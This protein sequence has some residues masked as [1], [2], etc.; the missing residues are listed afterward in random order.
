M[1]RNSREQS[2]RNYLPILTYHSLDD[3]GSVVSIS[4][5]VFRQ[6]M[7]MLRAQGVQALTLAA[8]IRHLH[9][10]G[11]FPERSVVI[12]FDD[13]YLNVFS[14]AYPV[15]QEYSFHA[16][17]F[18]ITGY[19]GAYNDWPGHQSPVGRLPLMDWS[20]VK[21]MSADGFEFG[22][23]TRSHP[24]LSGIPLERAEE[25]ILTSQ[26]QIEDKLGCEVNSFAYP[27][28]YLNSAVKKIVQKN[29]ACA[30]SVKLGQA[31]WPC[32]L[33]EL[34]RVDM[35]YVKSGILFQ[36]LFS[37]RLRAYLRVRQKIRDLRQAFG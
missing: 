21:E 9:A 36:H 11:E 28:G 3:S 6:Q 24:D 37:S 26:K 30:C 14:E 25:E 20:Q 31:S 8:A 10:Y 29:F 19:C 16:T 27:Y 17:I 4:A 35:Y 15:L 7:E 34:P 5:R 18:L 13:G 1:K 23:H 33:F 2:G 32:D 12:T 22:A